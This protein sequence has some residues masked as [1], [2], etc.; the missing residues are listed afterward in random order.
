[1][2]HTVKTY[3]PLVAEIE[4]TKTTWADKKEEIKND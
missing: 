4:T 3:V 2:E 1:M